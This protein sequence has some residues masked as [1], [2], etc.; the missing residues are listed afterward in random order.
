MKTHQMTTE[1]TKWKHEASSENHFCWIDLRKQKK[2]QVSRQNEWMNEWRN[3]GMNGYE[4]VLNH[5]N[6]SRVFDKKQ[7]KSQATNNC[8]ISHPMIPFY[9]CLSVWMSFESTEKIILNGK[10]HTRRQQATNNRMH[11]INQPNEIEAKKTIRTQ[12]S[13]MMEIYSFEM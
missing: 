4:N 6:D 3:E 12:K 9:A 8:R 11:L 1:L 7:N 5:W 13:F 10:W 2:R